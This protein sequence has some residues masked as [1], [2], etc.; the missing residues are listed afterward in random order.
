MKIAVLYVI[1]LTGITFQTNAQ[2]LLNDSKGYSGETGVYPVVVQE[3]EPKPRHH[4]LQLNWGAGHLKIQNISASPMIHESWSPVNAVLQYDHSNKLDHQFY[5][6]FRRYTYQ[7]GETFE[8][9][10]IYTDDEFLS[11][12]P[13]EFLFLDINYSLGKQ[14]LQPSAWKLTV[15]GRS[16]NFLNQTYYDFGPAGS[17]VYYYS[18]GLDV[19]LNAKC[20]LNENHHFTA[21]LALPILS[22]VTRSPYMTTNGQYIA[23]NQTRKGGDALINYL[24]RVEL[25]SWNKRQAVNF[26]LSYYYNISD[27]W[28]LGATYWLSMNFNNEPQNYTAIENIIQLSTKLNF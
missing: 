14:V 21:N 25:Q 9:S 18:L 8:Y 19:W 23:D 28:Q 24:K 15:G 10:A 16:S 7:M 26:D 12:L 13:H 3:L 11:S 4:S 22:F 27:K 5:I 6:R 20:V 1:I 17:G 2:I